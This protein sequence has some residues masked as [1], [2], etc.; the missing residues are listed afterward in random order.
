MTVDSGA[1]D[2]RA[3]HFGESATESNWPGS[4][5]CTRKPLHIRAGRV[6]SPR[7]A[8]LGCYG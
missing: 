4:V 8:D 1:G 2:Y 3:L 6:V 7:F 5:L